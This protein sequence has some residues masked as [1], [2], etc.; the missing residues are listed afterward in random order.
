[1]SRLQPEHRPENVVA[2]LEAK[3]HIMS[4]QPIGSS[5]KAEVAFDWK[6][7]HDRLAAIEQII[8]QGRGLTREETRKILRVRAEALARE[9]FR[10]A[11]PERNFD[12]LEFLIAHEH[13]GIELTYVREAYPLKDLTPVPGTPNFI[14][15]I[16]NVR[17]QVLSIIDLKRLFGLPDRGLTDFNKII[18][19]HAPGM[20]LGILADEVLG[21][22]SV[23]VSEIQPSLPTLKGIREKFLQGVTRES[24]VLLDA[25]K[26]L[27]ARQTGW[28]ER[29]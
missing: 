5:K 8:D 23:A 17:G 19:V 26:L 14:L 22:K 12:V 24:M 6:E 28:Q 21:L 27:S 2:S 16:T 18:I 4:E 11:P 13:Y 20:E 1:V 10:K 9:P 29:V 25:K 15:G 3:S 7:S